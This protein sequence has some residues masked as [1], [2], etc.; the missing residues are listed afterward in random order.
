MAWDAP[1]AGGWWEMESSIWVDMGDGAAIWV[2]VD[3][4]MIWM[5]P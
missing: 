4:V 5:E 3:G 1:M 2:D